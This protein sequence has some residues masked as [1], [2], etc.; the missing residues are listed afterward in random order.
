MV[1]NI[2][3]SSFGCDSFPISFTVLESSVA[4][5]E[6]DDVTIV[7]LSDNNSIAI[8][9]SN[10]NLGIGD[11]E[12]SLDDISGPYQDEPFFG[13]IGAGVHTIYVQDKNG[14]DIAELE[15]FVMG[16]PKFFTPNNDRYNDTW[17]IK[18]LSNEFT[19]NSTVYI[20]DRYGK[21]I[22]Q[23]NPRAEGW[24]GTFNGQQLRTSD[25]WFVVQLEN[26]NGN[27]TTYRGH[28]SLIR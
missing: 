17:N 20:C 21:L 2:A 18:G 28:F 10:N 3:I 12:F 11:Y 9:N 6:N 5:I 13:Q 15:V 19:Q 8:N 24:D 27:T 16:F 22:K 25:Y 26:V 14:C 1:R 23:I 7:E 4:D